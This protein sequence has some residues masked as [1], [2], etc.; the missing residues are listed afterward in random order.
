[1]P[2]DFR[3]KAHRLAPAEI[4]AAAA[5]HGFEP[6]AVRAVLSVETSGSGF[7]PEGRPQMLF[8]PHVFYRVLA[9]RDSSGLGRACALGL[10]Y[11]VWGEKPYPA[12]SYPRMARAREIDED[13]AYQAASWGI[14]Q[15][16][17]ENF[18]EAG[19]ASAEA[20]VL[21]AVESEAA[22][23]GAMLAFIVKSGLG[24]SLAARDWTRFANGYNGKGQHEHNYDQRLAA[25][26]A[27][28]S[29]AAAVA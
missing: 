2:A 20:L 29:G 25:A 9:L 8:E 7:D 1:V 18:R 15:V 27:R 21:A 16:L 5:I 13:A 22:Q 14:G 10:A 17:G 12:D 11:P 24:P 26:Y 28:L 19:F 4:D 6:A 23:L 3:G